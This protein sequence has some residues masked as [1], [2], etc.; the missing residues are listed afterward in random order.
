MESPGRKANIVSTILCRYKP[1]N[2]EED[3]QESHYSTIPGA[4]SRDRPDSPGTED[5]YQNTDPLHQNL[6]NSNREANTGQYTV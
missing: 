2:S 1:L 6:I 3:E 5:L 4:S